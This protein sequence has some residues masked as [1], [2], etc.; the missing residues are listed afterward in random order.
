MKDEGQS[1]S[2]NFAGKSP[3][4]NHSAVNHSAITFAAESVSTPGK[5]AE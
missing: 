2:P 1:P 3:P 5:E 4:G